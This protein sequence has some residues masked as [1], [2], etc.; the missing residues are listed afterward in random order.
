MLIFKEN[1]GVWLLG[2]CYQT[3]CTELTIVE[4][5]MS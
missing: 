3:D 5:V 4:E 1:T 2:Y